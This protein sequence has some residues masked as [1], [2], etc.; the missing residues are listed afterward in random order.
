MRNR[1]I[2]SEIKMQR[3]TKQDLENLV[4][5]I[6]QETGMPAEP[7]SHLLYG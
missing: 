5:R 2:E 6:N 7:Y 1:S 4:S 3:I